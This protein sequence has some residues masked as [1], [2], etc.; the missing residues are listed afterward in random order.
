MTSEQ[1]IPKG[2]P[3][4]LDNAFS[5]SVANTE[6]TILQNLKSLY[7]EDR[8]HHI[9]LLDMTQCPSFPLSSFL[10]IN[11]IIPEILDDPKHDLVTWKRRASSDPGLTQSIQ[12]PFSFGARTEKGE[13][14]PQLLTGT[15]KFTYEGTEFLVFK[16]SWD[17]GLMSVSLVDVVS[18]IKGLP[19]ETPATGIGSLDTPGHALITDV[20]RWAGGLKDEMWVF[21]GGGWSKDKALWAAICKSSWDDIILEDGFLQNLRKDTSTF[22]ENRGIYKDL[23]VVW[24]RG[25]LLLGP[26]GNGKTESIK[27]LLKETKQPALYVKSFTTLNV[28]LLQLIGLLAWA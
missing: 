27:V 17:R 23:N 1:S 10:E 18:E 25:I 22:F 24:K 2:Y 9:A 5:A 6:Y 7:P 21:Q 15:I 20:F 14:V 4:I 3:D 13:L 11:K 26:P 19:S 8:F 28:G 16:C 12:D